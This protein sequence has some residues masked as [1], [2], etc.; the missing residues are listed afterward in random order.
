MAEIALRRQHYENSTRKAVVSRYW[1]DPAMATLCVVLV[2]AFVFPVL[3]R[4]SAAHRRRF[5]FSPIENRH[6]R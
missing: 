4:F 5:L 3:Y 2:P 1:S 6:E